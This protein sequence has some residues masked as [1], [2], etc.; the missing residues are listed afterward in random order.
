MGRSR[1][2]WNFYQIPLKCAWV[3]SIHKSQSITLEAA[4]MTLSRCFCPGQAYVALSRVQSLNGVFLCGVTR[5]TLLCNLMA[6]VEM[7][8]FK[9]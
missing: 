3:M 5:N 4:I 9:K 6:G 8:R 1:Q 2:Q 7:T